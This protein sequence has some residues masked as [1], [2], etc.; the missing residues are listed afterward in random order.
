[1]RK[2][3]K[4]YCLSSVKSK[5]IYDEERFYLAKYGL[6]SKKEL[7]RGRYYLEKS[8][9]LYFE[10]EQKPIDYA[11]NLE[12]NIKMGFLKENQIMLDITIDSYFSRTL[13]YILS[14]SENISIK[15][16][17]KLITSG[18]V[19]YL[20]HRLRSPRT[21]IPISKEKEIKLIS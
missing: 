4:K 17:R 6:R 5:V 10:R 3:R 7:G 11:N 21:I 15:H 1:M 8:R 16:S 20:S 13:A 19:S 9:K 14:V 2:L 18:R 12:K